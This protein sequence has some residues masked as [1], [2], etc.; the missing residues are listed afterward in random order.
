MR[1]NDLHASS[2]TS[3]TEAQRLELI[4]ALS[5]EEAL[6]LL[7]D[8]TFWAREKQLPPDWSWR[9]WLILTGRGFGKTRTGAEWVW[10]GGGGGFGVG[11]VAGAAWLRS[12]C[13]GGGNE[14]RCT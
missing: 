13:T 3:L 9:T 14:S 1:R 12:D 10:A 2:L 6:G 4:A 7:Y 5:D 8:W 11:V